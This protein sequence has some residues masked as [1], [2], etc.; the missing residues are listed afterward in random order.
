MDPRREEKGAFRIDLDALSGFAPELTAPEAVVLL[1]HYRAV[2]AHAGIDPALLARQASVLP[3]HQC[4][5]AGRE[6]IAPSASDLE[7]EMLLLHQ[8]PVARSGIAPALLSYEN[9]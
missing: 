1:L 7:S 6:G 3:I 2:A 8:R 4:A 9:S 5:M